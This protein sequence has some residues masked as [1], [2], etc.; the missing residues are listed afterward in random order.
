MSGKAQRKGIAMVMK[1]LRHCLLLA[2][3]SPFFIAC[4]HVEPLETSSIRS[5][6]PRAA[7]VTDQNIIAQTVGNAPAGSTTLAWANPATGSAGVIEQINAV[8]SGSG[9]CRQFVTTQQ[10]IV[11]ASR[12]DGTACPS[13]GLWKVAGTPGL[14]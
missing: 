5:S 3:L 8:S 13:N 14:H 4:S 9:G 1:Q 7:P 2:A 12:F 11:G 10:T 6:S